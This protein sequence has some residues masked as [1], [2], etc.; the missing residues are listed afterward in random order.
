MDVGPYY[1]RRA[2]ALLAHATQVDPE[3]KFWFGLPQDKAAA[4]YPYDD[5]ILAAARVEAPTPEGDMFAGVPG[6]MAV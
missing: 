4:A 6:W 5:Y 3:S 1:Q 2:D